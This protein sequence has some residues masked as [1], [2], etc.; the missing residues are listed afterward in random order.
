MVAEGGLLA[1]LYERGAATSVR[2]LR[3]AQISRSIGAVDGA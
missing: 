3:A 2:R 1:L